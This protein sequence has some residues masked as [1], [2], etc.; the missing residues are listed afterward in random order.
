M[1]NKHIKERYMRLISVML[2]SLLA[3]AG[4][5]TGE[6]MK[7]PNNETYTVNSGYMLLAGG[8]WLVAGKDLRSKPERR[9]LIFVK[10][11]VYRWK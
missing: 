7:T 1:V 3:L 6:V 8:W 4:C 11:R 5:S 2:G 10:Q 9:H